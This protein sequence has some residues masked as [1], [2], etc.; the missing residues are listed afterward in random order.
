MAQREQFYEVYFNPR[1]GPGITPNVPRE[2]AHLLGKFAAPFCR[3]L[4]PLFIDSSNN[5]FFKMGL[6]GKI[7]HFL[8]VNSRTG[9]ICSP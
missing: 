3:F 1:P 6:E 9:S 8:R 7:P 4:I 5:F 2:D